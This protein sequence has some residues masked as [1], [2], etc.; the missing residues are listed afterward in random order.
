[1]PDYVL[2]AGV[3]ERIKGFVAGVDEAGRGPF[4]GPVVAA[5]V[6]LDPS[7]IP[8]GIDDSKKIAEAK[9]EILFERIMS[10]ALAVGVGQAGVEEIEQINILQATFKAMARAVAALDPAPAFALIDGRDAPP[11]SCPARAVI[12]GDGTSLS[13]AAASIVAKVTRD[14][15][16]RKLDAEYPGYGWAKNKGYGT[17]AHRNAI[18]RLGTTP[19]H[20]LSFIH[21]HNI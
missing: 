21:P 20:R 5:A 11:M 18:L 3:R 12:K 15:M 4:A 10:A 9:R 6:I 7:N 14:R 2:E 17:A 13:I 19:H 1:M 8:A 16:M